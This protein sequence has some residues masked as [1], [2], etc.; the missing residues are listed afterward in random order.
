MNATP[1]WV[2]SPGKVTAVLIH[3]MATWHSSSTGKRR[4][5]IRIS[6]AEIIPY[7]AI[8]VPYKKNLKDKCSTFC[9]LF[10][11]QLK[12]LASFQW[13]LSSIFA[14]ITLQTQHNFLCRFC[15]QC[16]NPFIRPVKVNLFVEDRFR[17]TTITTLFPVVS[18]FSLTSV[19]SMIRGG[20]YLSEHT[21]FTGFVLCD[22][23]NG[24]F[25]A[26]FAFA[27]GTTGLGNVDC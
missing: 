20:D 23:V 25:S 19:Y 18:S 22:F 10:S 9:L 8:P 13:Q 3:V 15:L 14:L 1:L 12:M 27:V 26:V 17:L 24:V 5:S 11:T 2:L 4:T 16:Q 7:D 21:C 6:I